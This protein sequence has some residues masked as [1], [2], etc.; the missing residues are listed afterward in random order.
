ML[1]YILCAGIAFV[2]LLVD[3]AYLS[4]GA[5]LIYMMASENSA[6]VFKKGVDQ[7]VIRNSTKN[8]YLWKKQEMKMPRTKPNGT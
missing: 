4:Q 2:F 8:L 7:G 3:R 5:N 1:K 6:T